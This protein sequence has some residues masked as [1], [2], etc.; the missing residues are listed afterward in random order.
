MTNPSKYYCVKYVSTEKEA[1]WTP[2]NGVQPQQEPPV[3]DHSSI[4]S[5]TSNAV[6]GVVVG[7]SK[8][9]TRDQPTI[10]PPAQQEPK[11][12]TKQAPPLPRERQVA[13]FEGNPFRKLLDW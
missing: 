3:E 13:M 5:E 9:E 11:K 4:K 2:A 1:N 7:P 8:L 6:V 10:E 12:Q